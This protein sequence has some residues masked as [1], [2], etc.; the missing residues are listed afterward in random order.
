MDQHRRAYPSPQS[1]ATITAPTDITT[2]GR[3]RQP[4][5]LLARSDRHRPLRIAA[6]A[7]T[8]VAAG[9]LG[10][11]IGIPNPVAGI[12]DRLGVIALPVVAGLWLAA[13]TFTYASHRQPRPPSRMTSINPS[14]SAEAQSLARQVGWEPRVGR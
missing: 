12:A 5:I 13:A 10:A 11:R 6:A 9:W 8:A 4:L 7:A 1:P 3:S 14:L 2:A